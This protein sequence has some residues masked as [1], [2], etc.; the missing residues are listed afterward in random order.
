MLHDDVDATQANVRAEIA[1][2][3]GVDPASLDVSARKVRLTVQE[4]SLAK[5][6]QLDEV[7]R[8]EAVPQRQLFNNEARPILNADVL[9]NGTRRRLSPRRVHSPSG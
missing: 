8:I 7:R 2:A 5:I 6:A 4:G 9:V 1:A 3:A